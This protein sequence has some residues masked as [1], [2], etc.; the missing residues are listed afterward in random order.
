MRGHRPFGVSLTIVLPL[1]EAV[2]CFKIR[3]SLASLRAIADDPGTKPEHGRKVL[4]QA[5][6]ER[7]MLV[8]ASLLI[9]ISAV[10]ASFYCSGVAP[11]TSDV[12]CIIFAISAIAALGVFLLEFLRRFR[13]GESRKPPRK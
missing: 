11:H 1:L 3:T 10:S 6:P 4:T 12:A 5:T 2:D 8:L 7:H 13:S 9:G